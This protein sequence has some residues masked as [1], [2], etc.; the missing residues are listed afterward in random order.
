MVIIS[1]RDEEVIRLVSLRF[2]TFYGDDKVEGLHFRGVQ[3][4]LIRFWRL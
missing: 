3:R 4:V 2:L 1:H